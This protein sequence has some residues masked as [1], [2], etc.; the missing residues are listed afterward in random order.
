M[1][2][3]YRRKW[4]RRPYSKRDNAPQLLAGLPAAGRT[5]AVGVVPFLIIQ[6]RGAIVA[7]HQQ[8]V[9]PCDALLDHLREFPRS[10]AHPA[11]FTVHLPTSK[12]RWPDFVR[13]LCV[14]L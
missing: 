13:L 11:S 10:Q 2:V 8:R 5:H 9:G 4:L 14:V 1:W 3:L 7:R 6:G 12:K